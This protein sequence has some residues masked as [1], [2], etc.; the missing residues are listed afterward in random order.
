[1]NYAP[2]NEHEGI[3]DNGDMNAALPYQF[4]GVNVY[5]NAMVV[6]N[7]DLRNYIANDVYSNVLEHI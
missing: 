4:N 6:S 2:I 3:T 5:G 7:I 1:M